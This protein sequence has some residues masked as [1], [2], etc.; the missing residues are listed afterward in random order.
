MEDA[1]LLEDLLTPGDEGHSSPSKRL[2]D[3]LTGTT[4]EVRDSI[5]PFIDQT[6]EGA[7]IDYAKFA[8]QQPKTAPKAQNIFSDQLGK[9]DTADVATM[10]HD[11]RIATV[12]LVA[13]ASFHHNDENLGLMVG[14]PV[15]CMWDASVRVFGEEYFYGPDGIRVHN[16]SDGFMVPEVTIK[17]G[18]A[19]HVSRDDFVRKLKKAARGVRDKDISFDTESFDIFGL[20]S[21]DFAIYATQLLG[22]DEIPFTADTAD[23]TEL[24]QK[25][26]EG[27]DLK[28]D[29]YKPAA[30][31]AWLRHYEAV[32]KNWGRGQVPWTE[33]EYTFPGG[34]A[35]CCNQPTLASTVLLSALLVFLAML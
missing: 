11:A 30:R 2:G 13:H 15:P 26:L 17:L 9:D 19:D 35:V 34:N 1:G 20:S 28:V 3:W 21:V 7:A 5:Q 6:K 24:L 10:T 4:K 33:D 16:D 12:V 8:S 27:T 29:Q 31:R 25:A 18:K 32:V 14:V 23:Q 22:A